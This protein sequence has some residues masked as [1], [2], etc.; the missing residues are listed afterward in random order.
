MTDLSRILKQ[1]LSRNKW[2]DRG[3]T[4]VFTQ[5]VFDEGVYEFYV[6]ATQSED[7]TFLALNIYGFCEKLILAAFDILDIEDTAYEIKLNF[8]GPNNLDGKKLTFSMY[9]VSDKDKQ[10]TLNKFNSL[11][12]TGAMVKDGVVIP[13]K[14]KASDFNLDINSTLKSIDF[15][16]YV[17]FDIEK[18]GI[19]KNDAQNHVFVEMINNYMSGFLLSQYEN[20]FITVNDGDWAFLTSITI[21]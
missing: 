20:K 4:Y 9:H 21:T 7:I 18:Y 11:P 6:N 17:D 12:L 19:S 5:I 8:S 16:F 3:T 10:K 2:T 13:Y 15:T 1:I 14:G